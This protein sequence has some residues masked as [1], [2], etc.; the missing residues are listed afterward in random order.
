[1]QRKLLPHEWFHAYRPRRGAEG[2]WKVWAHTADV[3]HIVASF[4][5]E[6][7]ARAH[8]VYLNALSREASCANSQASVDAPRQRRGMMAFFSRFLQSKS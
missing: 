1:M 8:A 4:A 6:D 5:T 3:P 2:D 7:E